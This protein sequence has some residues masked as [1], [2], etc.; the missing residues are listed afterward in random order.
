M[1]FD[2]INDVVTVADAASLDLTAG[3]TLEA[4]VRPSSLGRVDRPLIVKQRGTSG[5]SYELQAHDGSRPAGWARTSADYTTRGTTALKTST[6][7]HIAVTFDG[8]TLRFFLNGVQK[9]AK[10]VSGPL[11]VG[12][13]S[14]RIGGALGDWFKGDVDD[15]R[16]W[17]KPLTAAQITSEMSVNATSGLASASR[18]KSRFR[19]THRKSTHRKSTR[20]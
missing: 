8:S 15:V 6:W 5:F 7:S 10:S 3:M 14:L 19:S 1:R 4:W 12:T 9:S 16:I 20:R 11:A 17:R 18:K 13:G 2:G